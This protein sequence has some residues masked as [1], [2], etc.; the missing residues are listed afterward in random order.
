VIADEVGMGKTRIAVALARAVVEAGG[1]VA[2]LIPPTLGFQWREELRHGGVPDVPDA[3]RSLWGFLAAWDHRAPARPWFD[4][5]VVLVAHGFANWRLGAS[6]Q[7]WR[8]ELLPML[9]SA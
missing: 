7:R 3:V 8:F 1:R 9:E 2:I 4:Q 5:P 6:T